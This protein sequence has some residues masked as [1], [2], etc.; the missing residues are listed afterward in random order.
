MHAFI[1]IFIQFHRI[2]TE[3]DATL[4]KYPDNFQV[5]KYS[6]FEKVKLQLILSFS[7]TASTVHV[8]C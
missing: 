6:I 1:F 4:P 3:T 8:F 5:A 2:Y 7:Y